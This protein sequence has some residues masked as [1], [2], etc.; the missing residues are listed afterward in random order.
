MF[1]EKK[2]LVRLII[3]APSKNPRTGEASE[4]IVVTVRPGWSNVGAYSM[5]LPGGKIEK[6]DYIDALVSEESASKEELI[7]VAMIA[8]IREIKEELGLLIEKEWLIYVG[9]STNEAKWTTHVLAVK[10]PEKPV[11][12][13]DPGSAGTLWIDEQRIRKDSIGLFADHLY[14]A[15]WGLEVLSK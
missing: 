11:L 3:K 15:Q 5:A 10:L 8:I 4:E 2:L 1:K 12:L 6:S 14:L 13:V 9:S 7:A